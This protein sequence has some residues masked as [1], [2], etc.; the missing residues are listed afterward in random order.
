MITKRICVGS[1]TVNHGN[2][3]TTTWNL[4]VDCKADGTRD[5]RS[6]PRAG[7]RMIE[8]HT[9]GRVNYMK[10]GQGTIASR[11]AA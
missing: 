8:R 10:Y 1:H 4:F 3:W 6:K 5:K 11:P 2:G 9:D 7:R